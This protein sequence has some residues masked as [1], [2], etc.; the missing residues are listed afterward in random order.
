MLERPV[1]ACHVAL[2]CAT[3]AAACG[4]PTRDNPYDTAAA[5]S[6]QARGSLVATVFSLPT[7]PGEARTTLAGALVIMARQ[8]QETRRVT[9]PDGRAKFD[10]LLAGN[11]NV[12]AHLAGY[13]D[14]ASQ[15][16]VTPGQATRSILR[17]SD[18]PQ[19]QTD[20]TGKGTLLGSVLRADE[21]AQRPADQDHSGITVRATSC[22]C[23][24]ETD[25]E[26]TFR[27]SLFPGTYDLEISAPGYTT[28][29][30]PGVKAVR[31]QFETVT[32]SPILLVPT[33]APQAP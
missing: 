28:V 6:L 31:N 8:G 10:D 21:V 27:L 30:L 22:T 11:Y 23:S 24:T 2:C 33:A 14:D 32:P 25:V 15:V 4:A 29:S 13:D 20:A 7:D 19:Q 16:S 1:L 17:L 5:T 18:A 12:T 9:G 26:G 3:L